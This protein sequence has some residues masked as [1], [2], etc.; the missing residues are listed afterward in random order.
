MSG[1]DEEEDY[2]D[3][4]E[5]DKEKDGAEDGQVEEVSFSKRLEMRTCSVV[6]SFTWC[7]ID[8]FYVFRGC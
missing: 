5:E 4:E 2:D 3:D 6:S 7:Q 1:E 8:E